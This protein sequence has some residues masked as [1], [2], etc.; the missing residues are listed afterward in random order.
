ME[1]HSIKANSVDV[2]RATRNELAIEIF[3]DFI[4]VNWHVEIHINQSEFESSDV[5][6]PSLG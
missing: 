2:G 4:I 6:D 5:K 1:G 3:E